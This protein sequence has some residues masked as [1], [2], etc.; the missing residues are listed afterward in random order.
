MKRIAIIGKG[1]VGQALLHIIEE[2]TAAGDPNAPKVVAIAGRRQILTSKDGFSKTMLFALRDAKAALKI[3]RDGEVEECRRALG[4]TAVRAV[5]HVAD[6]QL[7]VVD[8]TAEDCASF[9]LACLAQQKGWS[10]VT[11]NKKPLCASMDEF[12]E[13]TADPRR[14]RYEA[15]VGAGLPIISTMRDLL[16]SGDTI[17]HIRAA[18]SGTLT[19][20]T[21]RVSTNECSFNDAVAEAKELG[22]TEPDPRD[23]LSGM[24]VARKALILARTMGRV[25]DMADIHPTTLVPEVCVKGAEQGWPLCYLATISGSAIVVGPVNVPPTNPFASLDG[26]DNMFVFRTNRY[27]DSPLIIRGPGA[28]PAVTAAGIYADILKVGV[29]KE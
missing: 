18:A 2:R 16:A 27:F 14:Y 5:W 22:Y 8:C 1:K 20:I 29:D 17:Q 28:G 23:D 4:Q 25:A 21:S 24:D 7:V 10:I 9:H 6:K 26:T 19:Y 13:L 3:L 11:A 15:T 12:R